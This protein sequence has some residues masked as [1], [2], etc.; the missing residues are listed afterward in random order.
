MSIPFFK[1][2]KQAQDFWGKDRKMVKVFVPKERGFLQAPKTGYYWQWYT[3]ARKL[4][5]NI[6][7]R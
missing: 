1:T 2:K 6:A 7:K 5:L 3:Y 4:K